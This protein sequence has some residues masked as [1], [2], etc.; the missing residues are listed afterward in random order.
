ME[1]KA[2]PVAITFLRHWFWKRSTS[3]AFSLTIDPLP[4]TSEQVAAASSSG[5]HSVDVPH[6]HTD[7]FAGLHRS[8]FFAVSSGCSSADSTASG[9]VISSTI[10]PGDYLMSD[11]LKTIEQP[12]LRP[13]ACSIY[14]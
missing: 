13:E 7:L 11:D 3:R 14:T 10:S 9:R 6:P 4:N 1:N 8:M 12:L 5:E 2:T